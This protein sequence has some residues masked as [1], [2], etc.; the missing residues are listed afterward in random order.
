M[1][2]FNVN[3]KGIV[4]MKGEGNSWVSSASM[5]FVFDRVIIVLK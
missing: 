3:F 1:V 5:K 2:S 4:D